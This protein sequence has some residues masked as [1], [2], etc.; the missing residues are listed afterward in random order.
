MQDTSA[1][2]NTSVRHSKYNR[3]RQASKKFY[4]ICDDI[5]SPIRRFVVRNFNYKSNQI[6]DDADDEEDDKI[7][8]SCDCCGASP[9]DDERNDLTLIDD[10]WLCPS[11]IK[12][13]TKIPASKIE[14]TVAPQQMIKKPV[15]LIENTMQKKCCN[16]NGDVRGMC[17]T[18]IGNLE[19]M[20]LQEI[21][22]VRKC[23]NLHYAVAYW[24]N[25]N[26]DVTTR[27]NRI[28]LSL[29]E[30]WEQRRD[31]VQYLGLLIRTPIELMNVHDIIYDLEHDDD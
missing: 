30:F 18:C 20:T 31:I 9:L 7:A 28:G 29:L 23:P 1:I 4:E 11:C 14:P 2:K 15:S 16:S 24:L 8:I 5:N 6:D 13:T 27:A 21:V 25:N 22:E 26:H 17:F 19:D 10:D 12:N 3:L